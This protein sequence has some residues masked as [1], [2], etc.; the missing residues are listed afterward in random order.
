M[1]RTVKELDRG[2]TPKSTPIPKTTQ[3]SK[4]RLRRKPHQPE[5]LVQF[6]R[7][8]PLVGVDLDLDRD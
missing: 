5:S 4:A 1:K 7:R 3:G 2:L 8:S 6:F